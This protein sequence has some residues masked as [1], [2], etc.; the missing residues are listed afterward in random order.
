LRLPSFSQ[1]R[2]KGRISRYLANKA[3]IASRIDCFME[4]ATSAF[5]DKMKEQVWTLY[6][7]LLR[8]QA[9]C[10]ADVVCERYF[11]PVAAVS[12]RQLAMQLSCCCLH[13]PEPLCRVFTLAH[14][15]VQQPLPVHG[16]GP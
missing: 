3:S 5:G 11:T 1:A 4:V 6:C 16:N 12:G 14:H 15:V 13:L 9:F 2:N 8:W 10:A 7:C